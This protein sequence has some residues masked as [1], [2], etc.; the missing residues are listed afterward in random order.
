MTTAEVLTAARE[1][2]VRGAWIKGK[3]QS[4]TKAGRACYCAMGAVRAVCNERAVDGG[5]VTAEY[6]LDAAVTRLSRGKYSTIIAFNDAYT[7]RKSGV[8]AAFTS[9][10]R[11]AKRAARGA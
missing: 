11:A 3:Y 4:V 1:K 9:A 8:I 10:I 2:L 6:A 5:R 7:T